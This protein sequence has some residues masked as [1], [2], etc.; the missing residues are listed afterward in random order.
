MG[1]SFALVGQKDDAASLGL[2]LAQFEPQPNAI[3]GVF[4]PTPFQGVPRA[5][6]A[7]PPFW[8]R[9]LESCDL[10]IVTPSRLAQ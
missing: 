2:R 7:K 3:D 6:E 8:R 10:E 9:T 1:E 5:T 4:V